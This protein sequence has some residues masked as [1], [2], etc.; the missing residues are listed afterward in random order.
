MFASCTRKKSIIGKWQMDGNGPILNFINDSLGSIEHSDTIALPKVVKF[1]Y[2][3]KEDTLFED[4]PTH[5][6]GRRKWVIS[7]LTEDSLIIHCDRI[8]ARYY[9]LQ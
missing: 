2:H 3:I 1:K 4:T 9:H 6:Y 8:K 7:K 5:L